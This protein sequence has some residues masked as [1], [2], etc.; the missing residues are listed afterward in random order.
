MRVLL[1][2]QHVL[3]FAVALGVAVPHARADKIDLELSRKAGKLVRDIRDRNYECVGVLNFQVKR[4]GG[5]ANMRVGRLNALMATRLENALILALVHHKDLRPGIVCRAGDAAPK[6]ATYLNAAGRAQLLAAEYPLAW[7]DKVV[8]VNAFLT[9]EVI[10]TKDMKEADVIIQVFDDR[11]PGKFQE[12][13][14]FKTHTTVGMLSDMDMDFTVRGLFDDAK[15]PAKG[16]KKRPKDERIDFSARLQLDELLPTPETDIVPAKGENDPKNIG[17]AEKKQNAGEPPPT[18]F[19]NVLKFEVYYDKEPQD[20]VK[21]PRPPRLGQNVHFEVE[22]LTKQR[23]GLVLRVN[24]I[25]TVDDDRQV[26]DPDKYARWVLAPG[27]RYGIY[28]FYKRDGDGGKDGANAIC[29]RFKPG[30]LKQVEDNS[31]LVVQSKLGKIEL[32]VFVADDDARNGPTRSLGQ[33]AE[34]KAS[35]EELS[36]AVAETEQRALQTPTDG[37]RELILVDKD[38]PINVRLGHQKFIGRLSGRA[39]FQYA[40]PPVRAKIGGAK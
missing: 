34:R 24:G 15:K 26:K 8:K 1:R 39:T 37:S 9:G 12:L 16:A 23:L 21:N 14:R 13:T 27:K 19:A 17:G 38:N 31:Q 35:F 25:N 40:P 7:G 11:Q 10:F 3:L 20:L 22:N 6:G 18:P 36:Q 5:D 30:L 32:D 2:V 33:P 28:G 4:Q 29:E